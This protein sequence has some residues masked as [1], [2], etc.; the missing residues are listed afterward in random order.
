M[1]EIESKLLKN[2]AIQ[3][4]IVVATADEEGQKSLCAYFTST[5][6]EDIPMLKQDLTA[7]LPDYMIPSYFVQV[8]Q[9][10]LTPNGKIDRKALPKPIDHIH[11]SHVY[12]EPRNETEAKLL[13]IWK[14]TLGIAEE[15]SIG[16]HDNFFDLGGHSLKATTL[17]SKIQR[18][19]EVSIMIKDIFTYPT[20]QKMAERIQHSEVMLYSSIQKVDKQPYYPVS[21]AQKRIYALS[22]LEG[23]DR[24]Y[25]MPGA[26]LIEGNLDKSR[27]HDVLQKLVGRHESLRTS[28]EIKDGEPVQFIHSSIECEIEYLEYPMT[29]QAKMDEAQAQQM[30]ALFDRFV[31]A[32]VLEQAPLFR[33]CLVK[34]NH[35]QHILLFDMHHIISDGAT[36]GILIKEFSALYKGAELPELSLQY[37]DYAVWQSTLFRS[38]QIK[39][40]EEYWLKQLGEDL[41]VLNMPTDYPRPSIQSF[42]GKSLFFTLEK[43]VTDKLKFMGRET[44]TSL[45]MILLSAYTILLSKYTNQ[46]DIVVGSP[47]AGR[48]HADLEPLIGMFVNTLAMRN[49]PQAGKTFR[50]YLLE[51]KENAL[52]AF[53]NQTYPFEQIV[54]KLGVTRDLSRNPIFDTVFVLQSQDVAK[55]DVDELRLEP[56]IL[57]HKTSKFDITLNAAEGDKGLIFNL[58]YS[59]KLFKEETMLRFFQHYRNVLQQILEFPDHKLSDMEI[60]SELER[61]ELLYR[62]NAT[63]RDYPSELSLAERFEA[64]VTLTPDHVALVFGEQKLSYQELNEKASQVARK[65]RQHD[66]QPNS[67]V[68]IMAERSPEMIIGILGIVKAG[69]AYLPLDPHYPV[70]RIQYMVAD[71]GVNLLLTQEQIKEQIMFQGEEITLSKILSAEGE[72]KEQAGKAEQSTEH[73]ETSYSSAEDVAYIIYTSGSTGKPKGVMA[74]QRGVMRLVCNPDYVELKAGDSLLQTGALVFDASTFEI[75][76]AL[77][78]GLT[79]VL[80]E[81]EVILDAGLL[82]EALNR[83]QI[84]TMW[85]TS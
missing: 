51:V 63:E 79:L 50:Q 54:E 74:T 47:I 12:E 81:D 32:F 62:F 41:P 5:R 70:E 78:N 40:Q 60:L 39:K 55:V 14:Q 71:A 6:E 48:A 11:S 16:I 8:E 10:P 83:H 46:E 42:E 24:N 72:L 58:E 29:V 61:E 56:I 22:N 28:F 53:E 76:G 69:G 85:L 7:Y 33:V 57:D 45:Y 4:A 59:T 36:M 27:L 84:T 13:H 15:K 21:S 30:Q 19:F 26:I 80:V 9:M 65:L 35:N 23:G 75:W 52:Q 17:V 34:V 77:L 20:V 2:E 38:D 18:D 73:V 25:N 68:G 64:Q 82:E 3:E 37:K 1:G 43:T 31:K 66:V 67:V 44:G 49:Q